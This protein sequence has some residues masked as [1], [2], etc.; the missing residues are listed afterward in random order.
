[1]NDFDDGTLETL[2]KR[3]NELLASYIGGGKLFGSTKGERIDND[4]GFHLPP[5]IINMII[6]SN[7]FR[8]SK[9]AG[10]ESVHKM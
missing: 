10:H 9:R 7:L 3:E 4:N 2:R 1:M 6:F 5:I 8:Q